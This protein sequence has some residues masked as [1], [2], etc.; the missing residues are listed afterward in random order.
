MAA[1][2]AQ[3]RYAPVSGRQEIV[4]YKKTRRGQ[5]RVSSVG[6][7]QTALLSAASGTG[8]AGLQNESK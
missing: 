2:V 1:A 7:I 5:R 8:A 3:R 6:R 4:K